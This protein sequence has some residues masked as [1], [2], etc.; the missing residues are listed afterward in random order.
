[1]ALCTFRDSDDNPNVFN[2]EHDD[3]G[4]WLNSNFDNPDNFWNADNT[5]VFA[6]RN[7]LLSLLII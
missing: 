1:M 3:N 7:S 2:V 4:Q 6:R 5:F